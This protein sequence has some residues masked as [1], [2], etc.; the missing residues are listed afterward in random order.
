MLKSW[1]AP[2]KESRDHDT[3]RKEYGFDTNPEIERLLCDVFIDL[4]ASEQRL[5][6]AS[7]LSGIPLN[8]ILSNDA[9]KP[10]A[11]ADYYDA[12]LSAVK[13]LS[14]GGF[15][16]N[17]TF[18]PFLVA[19]HSTNSE[20]YQP[21]SSQLKRVKM[22]LEDGGVIEKLYIVALTYNTKPLVLAHVIR[23]ISKS[24]VGVD[25]DP[26]KLIDLGL[27]S[28]H[29]DCTSAALELIRAV[30]KF[31]PEKITVEFAKSLIDKTTH[32]IKSTGWPTLNVHDTKTSAMRG[33]AYELLG[34]LMRQVPGVMTDISQLAFLFEGL[35]KDVPDMKSSIQDALS[36]ILPISSSLDYE[37][38]QSLKTTLLGYLADPEYNQACKYVAV[39]YAV[40]VTPFSDPVGRMICLLGLHH[41]NRA[42][43]IEEARRGLHPHWHKLVNSQ[44]SSDESAGVEF[45]K[46]VSLLNA[47]NETQQL[48]QAKHIASTMF[49][50]STTVFNVSMS[51]L[52]KMLAVEG[53]QYV[54]NQTILT[55]DENWDSRIETAV[56]LDKDT[57][58]AIRAY[59]GSQMA[60]V[61]ELK[62]FIDTVYTGVTTLQ[63]PSEICEVWTRIL[64]QSPPSIVS[65]LVE[66]LSS[67]MTLIEREK[68]VVRESAAKVLGIV[69]T[70]DEVPA[71]EIISMIT[72]LQFSEEKTSLLS[73][74]RV[75]GHISTV[76]AVLSRLSFRNRL[77]ELVAEA[78]KMAED[79]IT[80]IVDKLTNT[81]TDNGVVN[82]CC[83]AVYQLSL[84]GLVER[85]Q[86][87]RERLLNLAKRDQE[88]AI[89]AL[90][91]LS[92]SDK[93]DQKFYVDSILEVCTSKHVEFMF[94][95]GEAL[96]LAAANWS[97]TITDRTLDI[98]GVSLNVPTSYSSEI[99]AYT[100]DKV[101]EACKSSKPSVR[102]FSCLWLLSLSQYCGK[103]PEVRERLEKIHLCFMRFLADR[104][105]I[106][107][108]SA[109]RGLGIIY[110]LGDE[111][112]KQDLVKG[113]VQSFTSESR[114]V[115]A[116]TVSEETELFE[117]GI[118][119]TGDGSSVTTYKD[120]LNLATEVGD[121]SLVYKFMSLA[122]H[123]ALWASRRGA[124]FGL[125]SI[126]S[127]ANLDEIFESN[128][129]LSKS[130]IPK[131]FR[132]RFDP[133]SSVQQSMRDIWDVLI[134]DKSAAINDNFNDILEE[135]L[136]GMGN[137]EWRVRQAS[138]AAMQDLLQGRPIEKYQSH[139]EEIW[140]MSFR[141]VDDIKESVRNAAMQLCR[142]LTTSLV[143][144]VDVSSGASEK[145]AKEILEK[146]IPFLTGNYGLQS[147]AEEVQTFALNTL[148]Q[149]C[150]KAGKA[151]KPY[152]PS[153]GGE[154]IELLSTLE[155]QSMNY[156]SLNAD[157]YGITREDVDASRMA[158][159][160]GSP[161][162]DAVEQMV[163]LVDD[164]LMSDFITSIVKAVKRSVGLPSKLAA[165]RVLVSLTV[166]KLQETTP[167]A[168][169]LLLA[170]KS[171]LTSNNETISQSY[172]ISAGYICRMA[173]HKQVLQYADYLQRLYFESEDEN[174]RRV[175][176][177]AVSAV[178]K[179]SGDKFDSLASAFLPF[180]FIATHDIDSGVRE[181]FEQTWNDNT[182]GT[183]AIK[184]H[185]REIIDIVQQHLASR[186]WS[187]RQV[188]AKSIAEACNRIGDDA[189]VAKNLDA[190]YDVLFEACSGRSWSGKEVVFD[191]LVS[192]AVRTK[193][194]VLE[195][196]ELFSK[197]N[198]AVTVE[199]KRKNKE[200]Q[201]E[202]IL[203]FGRY[204]KEFPQQELYSTL[205]EVGDI[206]LT[207]TGEQ[208]NE[209]GDGDTTMNNNVVNSMETLRK[210]ED[211]NKVLKGV[212]ASF[213]PR[214][215]NNEPLPGSIFKRL[216]RYISDLFS[217]SDVSS[218]P[219]TWK[220][221]LTVI[222]GS[223]SLCE[224]FESRTEA[225]AYTD[226]LVKLWKLILGNC[227][228]DLNHER[229]RTDSAKAAKSFLSILPTAQQNAV[230]EDLRKLSSE[231]KSTVVHA[232]LSRVI[233][234]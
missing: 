158:S 124:A 61:R 30:L 106:V 102:K 49:E 189:S 21:A 112:L 91:A 162:M 109:S 156:L 222:N 46:F 53:A 65:T 196:K 111:N 113:L 176:A 211:R 171:Q 188:S 31:S 97:S 200:Y 204:V 12:T 161:M 8:Q 66:N 72:S 218:I 199:V 24:Q 2:D 178:A 170:A 125:G 164:D 110:E 163:E 123:S 81:T 25:R 136:V 192:L 169:K 198:K 41:L 55:I 152:I 69:G 58:D 105:D 219:L 87:L 206:Y 116:G 127:K 139:L 47:F 57:R 48:L 126:L 22:D 5:V 16:Q 146:L 93:E 14:G 71:S 119:N 77:N 43:V 99:A 6:A 74:D 39:R 85:N 32:F 185:I 228:K 197:L 118:L 203:S 157:K 155:P 51:F 98:Q 209:D 42:D 103:L 159:L 150:K 234:L 34:A 182:G 75:Q 10:Y 140:R 133:N 84:A 38:K 221:K 59:L 230:L 122:G 186:Q 184:L 232:E 191:A 144:H 180:I 117:P 154:F 179:H 86:P 82:A 233:N 11:H 73:S 226:D 64:S 108:E 128:N 27:D 28:R 60:P 166:R 63:D 148:L 131:L 132:Y 50:Y 216:V 37:M 160:R 79:S 4:F 224:S 95:S 207:S 147:D 187:V 149:L 193:S 88:K 217:E 177:V 68:P 229:I 165:S 45:P 151:L 67:I 78:P 172:A 190:L 231:E 20:V 202:A 153:L 167:Y 13:L 70:C 23:L 220:T 36:E 194:T 225:E 115:Q 104:D 1:T 56:G 90:G 210:E 33:K 181:K 29:L 40:R 201:R 138:C 130:L 44:Y 135:L 205:F 142:G 141:V 121:P 3:M 227:A 92:I 120:I 76:A 9:S 15:D 101:L 214:D 129:R 212:L 195:D 134:K 7:P 96:T 89:L 143:R 107:Q 173:S 35:E 17:V 19:S 183:G 62:S 208:E 145:R 54:G 175:S 213:T 174:P 100:V 215:L 80:T 223:I 26:V 52:E 114:N 137:R 18:F 168:D 83:D 94:S